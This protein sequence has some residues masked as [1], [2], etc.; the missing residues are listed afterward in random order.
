M[1][2]DMTPEKIKKQILARLKTNL[3]IREGSFT[4]D[5]IAAAAMMS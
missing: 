1:F 5:I 2:E 4:H 3:Q